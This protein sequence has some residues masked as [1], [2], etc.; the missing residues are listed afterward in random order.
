MSFHTNC[1]SCRQPLKIKDESTGKRMKCPGCGSVFA[2][3]AP[4]LANRPPVQLEVKGAALSPAEQQPAP[5][6][7]DRPVTTPALASQWP[8]IAAAVMVILFTGMGMGLVLGFFIGRKS[9]LPDPANTAIAGLPAAQTATPTGPQ[10]SEG[11]SDENTDEKVKEEVSKPVREKK[12]EKYVFPGKTK[13][14]LSDP[15]YTHYYKLLDSRYDEDRNEV[16]WI[17]ECK[18]DWGFATFTNMMSLPYV[19]HFYDAENRKL[20]EVQSR[21]L[22]NPGGVRGGRVEIVME[23]PSNEVMLKTAKVILKGK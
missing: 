23:L 19:F 16:F 3:P 17:S 9:P 22:N 5:S 18:A 14:D 7:K 12:A 15:K 10:K 6:V 1:P 20:A 8:W 13:W 21:W 4:K 11:Q 2:V